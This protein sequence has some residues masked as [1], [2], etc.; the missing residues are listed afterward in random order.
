[1][2]AVLPNSLQTFIMRHGVLDDDS[3]DPV[4]VR[5]GHA[6]THGAA[7]ILHINRDLHFDLPDGHRYTPEALTN[8]LFF[9]SAFTR[10]PLRRTRVDMQPTENSFPRRLSDTTPRPEPLFPQ[11]LRLKRV[12]PVGTGSSQIRRSIALNRRRVR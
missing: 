11:Q 4:R 9:A 6:K 12:Q 8:E 5:Q 2:P 10:E 7:V 3:F 1:M